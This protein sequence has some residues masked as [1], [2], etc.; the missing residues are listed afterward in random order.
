MRTR[1]AGWW[2]PWA[3]VAFFVVVIAVN[4]TMV[5]FAFASWTGID[6]PDH[7]RRG[8]AYNRAI[9]AEEAQR[10][11]G[12]RAEFKSVGTGPR[13]A[14][15]DLVMHDRKG[16]ALVALDA[17]VRFVRPTSGGH[18]FSVPLHH[19]G[20]GRYEAKVEFPLHGLWAAE[21]WARRGKALHRI[22]KRIE[23]P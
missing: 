16:E 22:T 21:V 10:R 3:F 19:V 9:A 20:G 7:Y 6:T 2:W 13:H 23:V 17:G 5:G 8:L 4:G 1:Q 11:R 12:W 14:T 15:I 18:D